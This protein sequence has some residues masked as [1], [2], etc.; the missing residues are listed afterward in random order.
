M[1]DVFCEETIMRRSRLEDNMR[2]KVI[3]TIHALVAL[4]AGNS[5]ESK[6][7]QKCHFSKYSIS[8]L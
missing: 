2:A 7:D 3:S 8:L 6:R 4:A 5:T 1:S